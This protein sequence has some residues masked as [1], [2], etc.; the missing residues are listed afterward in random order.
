MLL[1]V[2]VW[3]LAQASAIYALNYNIYTYAGTGTSATGTDGVKASSSTLNGVRSVWGDTVGDVYIVEAGGHCIRRVDADTYLI[4]TFAGLCGTA[5]SSGDGGAA[6]NARINKPISLFIDTNSKIFFTEY[7]AYKVRLI[8]TSTNII[9]LLAGTGTS[10]QAADGSAA[11]QST[12]KNPH[13]IWVNSNGL[14]YFSELTGYKVRTIS[15]S[16]ILGTVVGKL[17]R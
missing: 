8:T 9:S 2:W 3:I 17:K 4:S 15:S 13:A 14:I 16:F 5:T 12:V 7:N 10:A 1:F 11:T 6:S